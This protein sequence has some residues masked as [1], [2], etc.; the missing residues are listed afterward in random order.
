M[1]VP[2]LLAFFFLIL[3][4]VFVLPVILEVVFSGE[5]WEPGFREREGDMPS[6]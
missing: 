5:G 1:L 4:Q 6:L 3:L 2:W